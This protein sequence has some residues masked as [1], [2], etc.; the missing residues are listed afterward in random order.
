MDGSSREVEMERDISTNP[1]RGLDEL[2]HRQSLF[3]RRK[4]SLTS[5]TTASSS[6]A[7]SSGSPSSNTINKKVI[8]TL[9]NEEDSG[10]RFSAPSQQLIVLTNIEN[11]LEQAQDLIRSAKYTEASQLLKELIQD[12]S[13]IIPPHMLRN[14]FIHLGLCYES[15]NLHSQALHWYTQALS[16]PSVENDTSNAALKHHLGLLQELMEEYDNAITSFTAASKLFSRQG[17]MVGVLKSKLGIGSVAA[18]QGHLYHSCRIFEEV[19][20]EGDLLPKEDKIQALLQL[21]NVLA[22]RKEYER[23]REI[24]EETLPEYDSD[25]NVEEYVEVMQFLAQVHVSEGNPFEAQRIF[26][27]VLLKLDATLQTEPSLGDVIRKARVS[28]Y[29]EKVILYSSQSH[30]DEAL[31]T[32]AILREML[33]PFSHQSH[34][35]AIVVKNL[36]ILHMCNNDFK[37]AINSFLEARNSFFAIKQ[38]ADATK[39]ISHITYCMVKA[40]NYQE[41][42]NMYSTYVK[43][44]YSMD[45]IEAVCTIYFDTAVAMHEL[46]NTNDAI[47]VIQ[48]AVQLFS[49]PVCSEI[50]LLQLQAHFSHAVNDNDDALRIL[51]H[52]RRLC[53]VN[54]YPKLFSSS[55]YCH[56][57]V[58]YDA[59]G[60]SAAAFMYYM[61]AVRELNDLTLTR[62]KL[63]SLIGLGEMYEQQK[64]YIEARSCFNSAVNLFSGKVDGESRCLFLRAHFG[65]ATSLHALDKYNKALVH[66]ENVVSVFNDAKEDEGIDKTTLLVNYAMCQL[67]IG[68]YSQV[69]TTLQSLLNC[70]ENKDV[71]LLIGV[72]FFGSNEIYHAIEYFQECLKRLI[73]VDD[74]VEKK[75]QCCNMLWR[76]FSILGDFESADEYQELADSFFAISFYGTSHLPNDM[77]ENVL[78]IRRTEDSPLASPGP[79]RKQTGS[80]DAARRASGTVSSLDDEGR[81]GF[82]P[83]TS[84]ENGEGEKKKVVGGNGG[85]LSV[86]DLT[87]RK[88]RSLA[89]QQK[90]K[91]LLYSSPGTK[92]KAS[93]FSFTT[94]ERVQEGVQEGKEGILTQDLGDET[95]VALSTE[96][97]LEPDVTLQSMGRRSSSVS[98][99][100][101]YQ[102]EFQKKRE[103]A[104]SIGIEIDNDFVDDDSEGSRTPTSH[105][106]L[107]GSKSYST[108]QTAVVYI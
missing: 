81:T 60:N 102:R 15:L 76:C 44:C 92:R 21:G 78:A 97:N 42:I 23:A 49:F 6:I 31:H 46:D 70:N 95:S 10:R 82:D 85:E 99:F 64:R 74:M 27:M 67:E 98:S 37:N 103:L 65:C 8:D 73:K 18:K 32:N 96:N 106:T 89:L 59:M 108:S 1:M 100:G 9:K 28:I 47:K 62:V 34:D 107:S 57:A 55:V 79:F 69:H 48:Q 63:I 40:E 90:A 22:S 5:I 66:Y 88:R 17:N 91:N 68:N 93:S 105:Q 50:M 39:L 45:E 35:F 86:I 25:L 26:D 51:K 38:Y 61:Q 33:M 94:T 83:I 104:I 11:K 56:S 24:V 12:E 53:I 20:T 2:R 30:W 43:E 14:A 41:L 58:V 87:M 71:F 52:C 54:N 80:C 7:T 84:I 3:R 16:L 19:L 72:A 13:I 36:G 101:T 77:M 4:N 75:T 29:T